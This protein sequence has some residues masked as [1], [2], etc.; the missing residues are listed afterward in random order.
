LFILAAVESSYRPI[1]EAL[2]VMKPT[3]KE[4][5]NKLYK[6]RFTNPI[7]I[8]NNYEILK[9]KLRNEDRFLLKDQNPLTAIWR[10]NNE[11]SVFFAWISN[12]SSEIIKAK[13]LETMNSL[14]HDIVPVKMELTDVIKPILK[15]IESGWYQ[16]FYHQPTS[17]IDTNLNSNTLTSKVFNNYEYKINDSKKSSIWIDS[18]IIFTQNPNTLDINKTNYY[19]YI[20]LS[21][22]SP[23]IVTMSLA[24]LDFYKRDEYL[25]KI[26]NT[27]RAQLCLEYGSESIYPQLI[28]DGH[29]KAKAFLDLNI[30]PSIINITK[31]HFKEDLEN[32]NWNFKHAEEIIEE[33][34]GEK[35]Y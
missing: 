26:S 24:E 28:I 7:R 1:S 14:L 10:G 4:M 11:S 21:G 25:E 9:L 31:L 15:I 27:E 22:M 35:L 32:N 34:I 16:L 5:D 29:H 30:A 19:K 23:S 13:E 3:Q 17:E 33:R 20:I 18:T 12:T 8:D 2:G 6:T